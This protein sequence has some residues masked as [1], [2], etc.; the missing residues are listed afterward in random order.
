LR[1]RHGMIIS[2]AFDFWDLANCDWCR[3]G[4]LIM[5]LAHQLFWK[6]YNDYW[7]LFLYPK[8]HY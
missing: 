5:N 3:F 8:I 2:M 1:F 7:Y 6:P 4:T